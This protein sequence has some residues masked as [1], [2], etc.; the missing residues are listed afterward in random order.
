MQVSARN[1]DMYERDLTLSTVPVVQYRTKDGVTHAMFESGALVRFFATN[2]D[3]APKK[4]GSVP[5]DARTL[6]PQT[7]TGW[8]VSEV[9]EFEQWYAFACTTMDTVLWQFRVICDFRGSPESEKSLVEL[10][11]NK[12]NEEILPQLEA[13][14]A[15]GRQ[16][17]MKR[18]F[19]IA[20]IIVEHNLSWSKKYRFLKQYSQT[21]KN[22]DKRL[23]SRPSLQEATVDGHLFE[24][25]AK[26]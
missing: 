19:T 16:F 17:V 22:Y 13:R 8:D 25:D 15:D 1:R 11:A 10:Y 18:G 2:A 4:A 26:M 7:S 3:L 12:W 9:A 14:F 6:I 24:Q 5:I 23:K 21:L 20:D